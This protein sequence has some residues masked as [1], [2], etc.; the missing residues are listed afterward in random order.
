M[1]ILSPIARKLF[2]FTAKANTVLGLSTKIFVVLP[3]QDEKLITDI[4]NRIKF[5]TLGFGYLMLQG[6]RPPLL[7]MFFG[8]HV[9]CFDQ[10]IKGKFYKLFP[11][12][13]AVDHRA[14]IAGWEWMR[15]STNF[16]KHK[17]DLKKSRDNLEQAI[18]KYGG[19]S[20][21]YV[22]GTGPSLSRAADR[23]WSNGFRIVCN[24][25][26]RDK[27]LFDH[28]N[29]HFIV[30][31]DAVYHFSHTDFAQHFRRDLHFR[32][33]ENRDLFFAY[34][35]TFDVIVRTELAEF[36]DRLIPIPTGGP[37]QLDI[38]LAEVFKLPSLG[39]VL[40]LLLLPMAFTFS[41]RA[42]LIGFDGRDP[43]DTKS[44]FWANS[45]KHSYSELMGT[46]Q[47]QFPAFFNH[48]VPKNDSGAYIKSVHE[49][50]EVLI[51]DAESRG[52]V[53]EM[54]H[55]SW[56]ETLHRRYQGITSREEYFYG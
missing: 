24:T 19:F 6:R 9:V 29:P 42:C 3:E 32:M 10:S 51:C 27:E 17:V 31:G 7:P 41:Q 54:L 20:K 2:S 1:R 43:K 18:A 48:F 36:D 47:D 30:A 28:I 46:L 53:I 15:F 56:T 4:K 23:D 22:F 12:T 5:Y 49:D 52:K 11:N 34:P 39:N 37:K 50:L 38:I 40:A 8:M 16:T 33:S 26:V 25:I 44:P 35:E 45:E 55:P 14:E 21:A 13:Y